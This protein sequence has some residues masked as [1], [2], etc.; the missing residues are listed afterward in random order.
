MI[1]L[2]S[3]LQ[4][5]GLTVKLI[6]LVLCTPLFF[7]P[8]QGISQTNDCD[9]LANALSS[10]SAINKLTIASCSLDE[11]PGTDEYLP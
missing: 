4:L 9:A 6:R 7:F 8:L 5:N 1:Q 11:I 3:H 2:R 10:D